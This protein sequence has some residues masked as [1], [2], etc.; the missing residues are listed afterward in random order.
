MTVARTAPSSR[1]ARRVLGLEPWELAVFAALVLAGSLP[2]LVLIWDAVANDKI[3]LGTDGGPVI[4]DQM[5][6]VNWIRDASENVLI[7]NHYQAEASEASYLHPGALISGALVALGL[8]PAAGYLLW[9]PFAILALFAAV[10]AYVRR[11]VA[12]GAAR[13]AALVLALFF[14]PP[15]TLIVTNEIGLTVAAGE[16]W[17][18]DMLW[19][20]F[21]SALAIAGIVAALVLYE[22][23]RRT[24]RVTL[25]P[26]LL[27]F[28][29]AWLQPWEGPLLLGIVVGAELLLAL[30][31]PGRA[32]EGQ[33]APDRRALVRLLAPLVVATGIPLAYYVV[34]GRVDPAW[35]ID[36]GVHD[37]LDP[38]WWAIGV[39]IAPLA[40]PALLAYR[41]RPTTFHEA[42]VRVWPVA[43]LA[44][45]WLLTN[46]YPGHYAPHALRGLSIPLAVLAVTGVASLRPALPRAAGLA[47]AAGIVLALTLPAAVD[48]FSEA[49]DR[50]N[51][52][53]GPY[54]LT[55]GE[56]DALDYLDR[57]DTPGAV[58]AP[59]SMGQLVPARTGRH[60]SVGNLFWTPDYLRRRTY[61]ELLFQGR[62]P[63]V[64]ARAIVRS[65]HARFLFSGCR[66]AADLTDALGGMLADVKRFDCATVYELR[67]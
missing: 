2:L 18:L 28:L 33:A 36:P 54:F 50:I 35:S 42:A 21:F 59:V 52:N 27:G 17:P 61:T 66:V 43:A 8:S 67:G 37:F 19:G 51:E 26:A 9:K 60:T 65:S 12:P 34:L 47:V 11:L 46:A 64:A 53:S 45:Y 49:R 4:Q 25:W 20:Y 58:Y 56:R 57:L 10:A 16:L 38:P 48:R 63:P 39:A 40:L 15:T 14:L 31:L 30:L 6:Y 44:L 7:S 62:L 23:D 29:S 1:R 13:A 41:Q 5:Q 55:R 24:G 3:W 32:A 22:R